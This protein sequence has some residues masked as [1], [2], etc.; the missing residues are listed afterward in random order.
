[1][2]QKCPHIP[3]EVT[4][5]T[6]AWYGTEPAFL[7]KKRVAPRI[8][9]LLQKG[10][11]KPG[12]RAEGRSRGLVPLC[13]SLQALLLCP[14]REPMMWASARR[15][16]AISMLKMRAWHSVAPSSGATH[17]ISLP[18]L[19]SFQGADGIPGGEVI[20]SEFNPGRWGRPCQHGGKGRRGRRRSSGDHSQVLGGQK[21]DVIAGGRALFRVLTSVPSALSQTFR[22]LGLCPLFPLQGSCFPGCQPS[23][24]AAQEGS[25]WSSTALL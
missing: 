20:F 25:E 10:L 2:A 21:D 17:I 13:R 9:V 12:Q 5:V 8:L 24:Q 22:H 23:R 18:I 7:G 15:R 6:W 3:W 19:F 4:A 14:G 16:E 11:G 1:M